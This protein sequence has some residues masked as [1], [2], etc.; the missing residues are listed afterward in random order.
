MTLSSDL[1]SILEKAIVT[2]RDAAEEA[3]ATAL[4]ILAVDADRA[5]EAFD[6][7]KRRLRVAL[8]AEARQLGGFERLV[9]ECAYE[10]WH[11]MLFARFLAENELLIHPAHGVPVTLADC[12]EIA[13]ARG[14]SDLWLIASEF[15]SRMLPGIFRADDP[16]LQ[17]TLAPEG[18]QRLEEIL[19]SLPREVFLSEDGLGW[20]YQY[21]QAKKKKEVNASERKIGG[22]DIAPVTQLFTENYMV[23]FLLE[24]TLGAWWESRHPESPLVKEWEYLRFDEEGKPAAGG[25]PGWPQ[26]VAE[27]TVMDPC[28]G[29]GHFL[30]V[31]FEMLRKMRMEAEGLSTAE[32]GDAVLRDNLFGLELDPRCTQIAAFALA[33]QAWKTGGYRELPIPNIACSGISAKGRLED[34]KKL[35]RGDDRLERSLERLHALFSDAGDLGSL[36]DPLRETDGELLAAQF[37][38]VA[39]LLEQALNREAATDPSAEVF[40][41]AAAGALQAVRRLARKYTLVT[42]NPP[43]LGRGKQDAVLQEF[44]EVRFPE[45][46]PDTATCFIQR[47]LRLCVSGGS[48]SMVAPHNWMFLKTYQAFREN[49]I[50]ARDLVFVARLGEHAFHSAQAAGAFVCLL[51]SSERSPVDDLFMALDGS[52]PA[53][54][55]K[56]AQILKVG[57]LRVLSQ[58][59][60]AMNPDSRII[61]EALAK[62]APLSALV[63]SVTGLQSNDDPRARR[64]FW[65]GHSSGHWIFEANSPNGLRPF[66]GHNGILNLDVLAETMPGRPRGQDSWRSRG[67]V[68]RLYRHLPVTLYY[69]DSWNQTCARL[70]PRNGD[71]LPAIWAFASS[72]ELNRE[73][74]RIDQKVNVTPATLSKVPFDAEHWR[75]Q[76]DALF[77]DGLPLPES[78]DPTQWLF[79]GHP[80]GS[81]ATLHVA[82]ARLLGY[83]WPRQTG[84]EFADCPALSP[85]GL[86]PFADDDGVVCVPAIRGER[87]AAE[88]LRA[89]L[90]AAFKE[91]WSPA[92][93]ADL[94]GEVGYAGKSL[95]QWLRD[96]FF[97]QHCQLFHQRSF[98][99]Q[100]WD[101][102]KDG[103]S[104]LV[105]YHLLDRANLEKLIYTYLGEWIRQQRE[106]ATAGSAGADLRLGAA[107]DL[108]GR[109][110]LIQKGEDPYD[111]F[112]R[113]KR[114]AEQP[115]G[116]EP[117]L[118]D[119]VRLNIRPFVTAGV[120]RTHP[121]IKW[122]KDPGKDPESAP[123]YPVF[124]GDRINDHHLSLG[125]KRGAR[126]VAERRAAAS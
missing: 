6:E 39:P 77:P 55:A 14:V 118:N 23:R 84:S 99:W 24:N 2:A 76:A 105:N 83:R 72:G 4:G 25:F 10:Q 86:E 56:K 58:A 60:Q 9:E 1:R 7:A 71:D 17:L 63:D 62:H 3:S 66:D 42:T 27:V 12:E 125:E 54:P 97:E 49:I 113:W 74:R 61:L 98:V 117:D 22:A 114:V 94:L 5:P 26:T 29:S 106:A 95:E 16:V 79:N 53:T 85:D 8:R 11:R 119:G 46:K 75:K 109:L 48:V 101:G 13:H 21:W 87:P 38:E 41:S 50:L 32:A 100:I 33:L 108:Q 104:A 51:S 36:I 64:M 96:G 73:V 30:V 31:A 82:I 43:F 69:G 37:E 57:E 116:W 78:S 44:C 68:V 124:K 111:I 59:E 90:A 102:R 107:Q 121:K 122:G 18:Q 92:K 80:R 126:E 123:W 112:V 20:A 34:W 70:V 45:G 89:L 28:C 120:L 88:R 91:E 110:E 35:A 47:S 19:A 40:G 93:E 115:I 67:I 15:A 103:F 65:E 52:V 81:E